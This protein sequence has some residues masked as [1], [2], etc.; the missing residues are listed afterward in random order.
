M[1]HGLHIHRAVGFNH[2]EV[3]LSKDDIQ[4]VQS[5]IHFVDGVSSPDFF[6]EK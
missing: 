4:L 1:A 3:T 2:V 5:T 6:V